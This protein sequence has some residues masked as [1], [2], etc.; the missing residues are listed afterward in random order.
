MN[1]LKYVTFDFQYINDKMAYIIKLLSK[2][3]FQFKYIYGIN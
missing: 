3:N 1:E 2:L